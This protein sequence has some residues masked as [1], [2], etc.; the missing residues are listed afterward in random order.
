MCSEKVRV[1]RQQ[2][3]CRI[4]EDL[5]DCS[6]GCGREFKDVVRDREVPKSCVGGPGCRDGRGASLQGWGRK[7]WPQGRV[8]WRSSREVEL[9]VYSVLIKYLFH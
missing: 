4:E 2:G 7:H 3:L 8:Q 9:Q 5:P 1:R 6:W